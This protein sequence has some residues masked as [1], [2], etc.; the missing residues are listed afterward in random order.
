[1][2]KI[3]QGHPG[4]KIYRCFEELQTL[5]LN[6]KFQEKNTVKILLNAHTLINAH[7]PIWMPKMAILSAHFGILGTSN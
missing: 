4:V 5:M 1:M 2:C 7:P 6:A 3:G